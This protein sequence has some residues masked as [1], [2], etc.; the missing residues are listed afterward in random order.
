MVNGA[1]RIGMRLFAMDCC[2]LERRNKELGS[3][4]CAIMYM[5]LTAQRSPTLPI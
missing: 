5:F 2:Y 1:L 4:I 3:F